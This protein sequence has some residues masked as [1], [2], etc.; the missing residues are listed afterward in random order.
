MVLNLLAIQ[1]LHR[2]PSNMGCLMKIV[3]LNCYEL[4]GFD[5]ITKENA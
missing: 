4:Q 3:F 5:E 1:L 2:E